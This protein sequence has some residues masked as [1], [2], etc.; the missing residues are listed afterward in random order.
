LAALAAVNQLA[1]ALGGPVQIL[2]SGK[3]R[4]IFHSD[5]TV[6]D[7]RL[8]AAI[9]ATARF[10]LACGFADTVDWYRRSGWL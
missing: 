9:G 3:V 8:A 5:W 6:K 10:D 4:E 7:R 1:K 2:T